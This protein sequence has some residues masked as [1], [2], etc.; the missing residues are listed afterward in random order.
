MIIYGTN[1]SVREGQTLAA[2]C[3]S[4][5][6]QSLRG[7]TAY[8][9]AHL[10]FVPTIPF[11]SRRGVVC[12]HCQHARVGKE[13]PDELRTPAAEA[14]RE[15]R[16]PRRH[17]LGLVLLA[18]LFTWLRIDGANEKELDEA[19]LAAPV[20]GDL[21]VMDLRDHVEG[22]DPDMPFALARVTAVTD[23]DVRVQVGSWV[24]PS[25]WDAQKAAIRDHDEADDYWTAVWLSLGRDRLLEL[26]NAD[27]L[28]L[29]ERAEVEDA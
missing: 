23:Q 19:R 18:L 29:A 1:S 14:T 20:V 3:P 7:F 12:E 8:G 10:F 25:H 28:G 5:G 22:L 11:G 4:C 24:Y 21:Y 27:K 2:V 13:L 9:F 15:L 16:R 17:W 6:E 26:E